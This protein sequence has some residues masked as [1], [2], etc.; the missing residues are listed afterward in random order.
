M[1]SDRAKAYGR[2]IKTLEDVGPSTLQAD[3]AACIREA[4]DAVFFC[5]DLRHDD[6][7]A[8]ALAE[9]DVLAARLVESGRWTDVRAKRLLDDLAA[10]GPV[11]PVA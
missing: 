1:T 6:T 3:E 9:V 4:A 10:C 11:A 8:L 2:V 5:E 7:A